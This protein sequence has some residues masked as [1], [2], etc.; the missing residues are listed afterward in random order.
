MV[1]ERTTPPRP[2]DR[3]AEA[4]HR[5]EIGI[6]N[7]LAV[8]A[9]RRGWTTAAMTYPGYAGPRGARVLGRLLLAPPGV[10]L[11]GRRDLA[12]WRRLLTLEQPGGEVDV[13]L[14][15]AS[16]RAR[17][18]GA[19]L[20][21]VTLPVELPPGPTE[22]LLHVEGRPPVR[23][24]VH[25]AAPDATCGVVCDIDDTVW[26]TGLRHPM[27]AAWRTLARS[28]GGR[29]PVTG[30]A[31]LLTGLVGGVE[32]GVPVVYLSNGPWNLAGPISRF[33]TRNGFPAGALLMTDWGT[34]PRAWFRDGR[35]HKQA[36]LERLAA[37]FPTVR[38]ILVGDDGEHDPDVYGDFALRRPGRVAGIAL[39][40]VAPH[41]DPSPGPDAWVGEV[42]VVHGRDGAE[43]FDRLK[44]VLPG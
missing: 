34:T 10:D 16:I 36:A 17:A 9:R 31:M 4:G 28:S 25:A 29:R 19:G 43:L 8:R 26:I 1:R 5:L 12:G 35:Q 44:G 33:L 13:T 2:G 6:R 18:D 40:T 3:L 23:A 27:R 21:D 20:V 22:A 11:Q 24:P 15:T 37:D 7:R 30:M 42:P 39:R 38:W 41:G 14:G 32:T